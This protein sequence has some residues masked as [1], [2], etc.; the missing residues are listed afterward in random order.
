MRLDAKIP[1]EEHQRIV[2]RIG[3]SPACFNAVQ[4]A[5]LL[6]EL[7]GSVTCRKRGALAKRSE[8]QLGDRGSARPWIFARPPR[9]GRFNLPRGRFSAT[10]TLVSSIYHMRGVLAGPLVARDESRLRPRFPRCSRFEEKTDC[11]FLA[12]YKSDA[13]RKEGGPNRTESG[14]PEKKQ[15]AAGSSDGSTGRKNLLALIIAL[16]FCV[17]RDETRAANAV[18]RQVNCVGGKP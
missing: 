9:R 10:P 2:N 16:R 7:I 18:T 15:G 3:S 4:K 1:R 6:G 5:R 14:S 8:R 17:E 13:T 12:R 11:P